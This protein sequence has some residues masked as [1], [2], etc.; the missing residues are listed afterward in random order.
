MQAQ[1]AQPAFPGAEGWGKDATGGGQNPDTR[2]LLVTSL[3]DDGPSTLRAAL[4]QSGPRIILFKTGGVIELKSGIS[5]QQGDVTI[6]GQTAPG[7]GIIIRNFP[8]RIGAS[9]VIMR[10]LRIRNGDADGPPGDLRDSLQI[11][12]VQGERVGDIIVDHCSFGWSMDETVEFWYGASNVT[13]S[14]CVIS[15]AL[16]NSKHA[17]GAHGY[18]MLFGH[19]LCEKISVHHNLFAHNERRNPWIKDNA[20]VELINNVVYNWGSECVG[21]WS[22]EKNPPSFANI[23]GNYFKP[24]KSS[25]NRKG[26]ARPAVGLGRTAGT[27]SKFFVHDNLGP[28]RTSDSQP[29]RDIVTMGK[30]EF[31]MFFAEAPL[32]QVASGMKAQG[33]A[34]AYEGVLKDA[35]A[36][37]RDAADRRAAEDTRNG[38]GDKID[39]MADLGGYPKYA[40]GEYPKDADGDGMPDAWEQAH[41]LNANDKRDATQ[42]SRSGS[43]YLNI[44][45]YINSLLPGAGAA[46]ARTGR[47]K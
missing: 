38:A 29:D 4:Q 43:G 46:A 22:E 20:Q 47:G 10:G 36:M 24:G 40:A 28:G 41:G 35:G 44:E 32:A 42:L 16:W 15:E 12:R 9:N 7:D 13:V 30:P 31:A 3:D 33:P 45:D 6:A 2:V 34:Q 19:G 27:G 14:W 8:I 25:T 18:G 23:I 11:S 37:P 1:A 21:I 17:K 5:I 39:T 26:V